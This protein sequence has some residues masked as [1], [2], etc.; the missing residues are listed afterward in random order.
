MVYKTIDLLAEYPATKFDGY[1]DV[2]CCETKN[3]PPERKYPAM[4]ICP[5]GGYAYCAK[6]EGEPIMAAFFSAGVQCFVLRYAAARSD[7]SAFYPTEHLQ[8][9]ASFDWVRRHADEFKIDKNAIGLIGFS[10]GGHLAGSFGAGL[11]HSENYADV[12]GVDREN[13]RPSA[14][15]LGYSVLS[16]L[17]PTNDWTVKNLLADKRFDEKEK[18]RLSFENIVGKFT[19]PTYLWHT[20]SDDI[21]PVQCS[22][23]AMRALADHGISFQAR[24][25]PEGGHGLSRATRLTTGDLTKIPPRYIADW[26]RDCTD[27][28]LRVTGYEENLR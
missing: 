2:Y 1:L 12:L 13:L 9:A 28:F 20:S 8:L 4:I 17:D 26:M 22:L 3:D 7:P 14:L 15:A 16:F 21:V 24:I 25:Y 10:A 19:P 11:W 18:A 23:R 6:I 27:W 5:G